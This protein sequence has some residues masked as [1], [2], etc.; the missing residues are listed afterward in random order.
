MSRRRALSCPVAARRAL[1]R[2]VAAC[3]DRR[4]GRCDTMAG[5]PRSRSPA[6]EWFA[7]NAT[8]VAVRKTD[9]KSEDRNARRAKIRALNDAFRKTFWG[10]R[11]MMTAGVAALE[12]PVR[13]AVVEKIKAF[14]A[15]DDDNDPWGEHDFVSVEH[16]GQTFFA[17]IDY[18]DRKLEAHSEDATDPE[19][20]C[21]VM[22]IMLAEEH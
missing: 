3:R 22:T 18:Y 16:D 17:K 1:S 20:T 2:L 5:E 8:E 21:R 15:F 12:A 6:S 13:N 7:G 19:K 4:A 14:D 11:V 9:R 10:G